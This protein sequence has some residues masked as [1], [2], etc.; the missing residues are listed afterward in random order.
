M[1]AFQWSKV[2]SIHIPEL[3]DEHRTLF[4]DCDA[5]QRAF[6]AG[7][8]PREMRPILGVLMSHATEHFAHE[9][10]L[11]QASECP[12][13]GWHKRQHEAATAELGGLERRIRRGSREA[14]REMLHFLAEWLN[15]HIRLADCMMGAHLQNYERARSVEKVWRP[16]LHHGRPLVR[17]REG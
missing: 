12:S 10:R 13:Y 16:P 17:Q 6:R 15:D 3:D 4:E 7:V 1:R 2:Y 11:M 14:T 8:D 9:E 5:L